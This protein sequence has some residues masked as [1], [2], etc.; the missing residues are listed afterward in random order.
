[1]QHDAALIAAILAVLKA[2]KIYLSLDPIDS[3]ERLA[4]MLARF[5]AGLLIADQTNAALADSL[6][7]GPL[8]ILPLPDDFVALSARTNFPAVS[9]KL[10]R[11]SCTRRERPASPKASGKITMALSMTPTCI[12]S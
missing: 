2:G 9:P 11:R 6:A 4:A 1:M 8:P 5:R 7:A 10:A 3:I 12:A